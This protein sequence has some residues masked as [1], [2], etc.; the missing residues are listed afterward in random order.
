MRKIN[1]IPLYLKQFQQVDKDDDYEGEVRTYTIK[2]TDNSQLEITQRKLQEAII[3]SEILGKPVSKRRK[4]SF[5][6]Y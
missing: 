3:W 6:G 2:K 1:N 4:R 5:Y